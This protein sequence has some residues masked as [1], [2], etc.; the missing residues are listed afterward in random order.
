MFQFGFSLDR[1]QNDVLNPSLEAHQDKCLLQQE[2]HT[3][4]GTSVIYFIMDLK[5]NKLMV[6][7]SSGWQNPVHI[8]KDYDSIPKELLRVRSN[9]EQLLVQRAKNA[10]KTPKFNNCNM[11]LPIYKEVS[12]NVNFYN[13]SVSSFCM[14]FEKQ[15]VLILVFLVCYIHCNKFRCRTL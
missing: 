10:N 1:T 4:H 15:E 9:P 13:T 12:N 5:H 7:C 2:F 8:Y 11:N 14:I 3:D 6:N